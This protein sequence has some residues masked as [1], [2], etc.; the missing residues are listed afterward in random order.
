MSAVLSNSQHT[1][2]FKIG[3]GSRTK[4]LITL[5]SLALIGYNAVHMH[6]YALN[7][8]VNSDT[9][10]I[11]EISIRLAA[12]GLAFLEIVI[13]GVFVYLY[14]T[15]ESKLNGGLILT[16][17]LA[18][19]VASM[20]VIAGNGSQ[21]IKA[22]AKSNLINAHDSQMLS[23]NSKI[24]GAAMERDISLRLANQI[25]DENQRAME[26]DRAN[27]EYQNTIARLNTQ[28]ASLQISRPIQ[29]IENG[30]TWHYIGITIFSVVCSFGA[31]FLSGYSAAFLKPLV[32]IPA[33]TLVSKLRH[34]WSSDGSDFQTVKHEVSPIGGMLSAVIGTQKVTKKPLPSTSHDATNNNDSSGTTENHPHGLDLSS[35]RKIDAGERLPNDVNQ[36]KGMTEYSDDHYGAIKQ[37]ILNKEFKPT[38]APVKAKLVSLKVR[39]VDDGAR[40]RK[41]VEILDQLK[42]EGVLLDNPLFGKGGQVVAKYIMNPDYSMSE[43]ERTI[44]PNDE[45]GEYDFITI[46]P[47]CRDVN[48]T[49][50]VDIDKRKGTVKCVQCHKG[51]V[52]V[53]HQYESGQNYIAMLSNAK[54]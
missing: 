23:I 16:G 28:K 54:K 7:M 45:I 50:V 34:A 38:Q 33:F 25:L 26:K 10:L 9:W 5:L 20:A 4:A 40:Q 15:S 37:A 31:L 1:S 35:G 42:S 11:K 3:A 52:A 51:H 39:F 43:K 29:A 12:V 13:G 17:L 19:V 47:H 48:I 8:F 6:D 36:K 41:A 30:S 53:S 32:A 44:N 27:Y 14:R 21:Q 49:H 18:F 24:Q 2:G 46:C 22:D